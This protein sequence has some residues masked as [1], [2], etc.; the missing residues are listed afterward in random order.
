MKLKNR[1]RLFSGKIF[2]NQPDFKCPLCAY[3]GQFV[4]T[5]NRDMG[6]RAYSHCPKCGSKERH[7]LMAH[8]LNT[9]LASKI[10]GQSDVL[11]FAPEPHIAALIRPKVR[12]Y[13]TSHYTGGGDYKFDM[14]NIELPESSFDIVIASHVL[15]HIDDD[16]R[17]MT[18]VKR[19]LR[20]GGVALLPVPTYAEK[21]IEYGRPLESGGHVRAPGPDYFSRMKDIFDEV[22]LI[23]SKDAPA[24]YQTHCFEN[25]SKWPT[26]N[27][28]QVKPMQGI[29]FSEY[30]PICK[31]SD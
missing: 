5:N 15:E 9:R 2:N 28:P 4:P 23:E 10:T 8:A 31:K 7:R 13:K 6:S 22:E 25:R 1:L 19:I 27:A 12:S 20:P 11:H 16:L 21:T 3:V 17:A 18:E 14:K 26:R 29:A 24:E 30:L